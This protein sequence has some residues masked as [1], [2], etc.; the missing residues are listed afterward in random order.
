M[1]CYRGASAESFTPLPAE[2][3]V[4]EYDPQTDSWRQRASLPSGVGRSGA[5]SA[6]V[7]GKIYVFGGG[8]TVSFNSDVVAA[9]AIYDPATDQWST[10]A[11]MPS[12]RIGLGVGAIDGLI[13][14]IGGSNIPMGMDNSS[15]V[16]R[17]DPVSNQWS[18]RASMPINVDWI[19]ASVY[20]GALY[21]IGGFDSENL[22]ETTAAVY[23]Y[24][25]ESDQ[26]VRRADMAE[27]R[28]APGSATV[29]GRI[30]VV[31]GRA[32]RE[33]APLTV[34]EEYTP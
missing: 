22:N 33:S 29:G 7:D 14:T 27:R 10:G 30:L 1:L 16:E 34:T 24:D 31:G 2:T 21:V 32:Q 12:P 13:Y 6:V 18:T 25:P 19:R 8:D 4:Q 11:D 5:A 17:Y 9:V 28:Y 20:G 23:R 15:I 3:T 26:W